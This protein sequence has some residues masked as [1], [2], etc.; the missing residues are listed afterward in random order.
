MGTPAKECKKGSDSSNKY[1][2]V[3]GF[4][5]FQAC[6]SLLGEIVSGNFP[7]GDHYFAHTTK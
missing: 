7:N 6:F 4:R 2:T 5:N 3:S 1:G